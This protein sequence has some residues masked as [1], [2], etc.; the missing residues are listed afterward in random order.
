MFSA[1]LQQAFVN[2]AYNYA[3]TGVGNAAAATYS[4]SNTSGVSGFTMS[5][6]GVLSGTPASSGSFNF[7]VTVTDG[8]DAVSRGFGITVYAIDI[9]SPGVLPNGVNRPRLM[10]HRRGSVRDVAR[11]GLSGGP[12]LRLSDS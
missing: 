6:A 7:T 11:K 9:T 5:S 10:P 4:M 1:S 3:F 8:T 12:S 2:T